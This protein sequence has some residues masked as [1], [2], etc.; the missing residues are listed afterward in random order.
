M[1]MQRPP[2]SQLIISHDTATRLAVAAEWLDKYTKDAEILIVAPTRE[3]GDEF[4]S[5]AALKA[6]SRF[7]LTRST[8]NHLAARLAASELARA[9]LVPASSLALTAVAARSIHLLHTTG[10]FSY[11]EPVAE[12]PGFPV[13]VGRTLEELRMNDADPK[14]IAKLPR[15][16]ADLAALSESVARELAE[17]QIAD[18]SRIFEAAIKVARHPTPLH[19]LDLPLLLLD[20]ALVSSTEEQLIAALAQRA[21]AVLATA[22]RGDERTI[23]YLEHALGCK[24]V[25]ADSPQVSA[26]SG[27][28]IL[29]DQRR[30]ALQK[31]AMISGESTKSQTSLA[32][33]KRHLFEDSCCDPANLDETVRLTS[34][35]GEARECVEIARIDSTRSCKRSRFRSHSR[36]SALAGRVRLASRRSVSPRRHS[37]LLRA[38]NIEA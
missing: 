9:G 30:S 36:L 26:G 27:S 22:A 13:A 15:G 20:V 19:P 31:S 34:W 38:R 4:V 6:G 32:S 28:Q 33:L 7:G 5:A 10:N 23:A 8:L 3:A 2:K 1:R 29:A 14:K 16:G 18:R 25:E 12:K 37:C 21:P 11:F 24:A 17:A 35:P